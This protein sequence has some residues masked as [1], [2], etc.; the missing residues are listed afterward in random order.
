MKNLITPK[1]RASF[2]HL[3][4]PRAISEGSPPK[5]SV[6]VVLDMSDKDHAAFLDVLRESALAVAREKFGAKLPKKLRMPFKDGD[7]E[8]RPEWQGCV[9]FGASASED[10]PPDIIGPDRQPILDNAE[11]YSGMYCR[12]SLRPYAW[13]H[14]TGGQGVSFGLGNVQKLADGEPFSGGVKAADEF[15]EWTDE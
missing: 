5:Y 2:A 12:C 14:P 11:V 6:T 3:T 7:E 1:F 13:S 9:V 8:D 4:K 15:A 10:F